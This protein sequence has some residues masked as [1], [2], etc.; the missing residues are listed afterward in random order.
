MDK[1]LKNWEKINSF[2]A[3]LQFLKPHLQ[4][5]DTL[6]NIWEVDSNNDNVDIF[7][8]NEDENENAEV[9]LENSD[10]I[11]VDKQFKTVKQT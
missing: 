8:E 11:Y 2:A 7:N 4:E 1:V 5:K 10:N 3:Q 6:G 9:I